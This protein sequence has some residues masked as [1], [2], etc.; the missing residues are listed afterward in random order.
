MLFV[1]S[2]KQFAI[3]MNKSY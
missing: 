3:K 2:A 1:I